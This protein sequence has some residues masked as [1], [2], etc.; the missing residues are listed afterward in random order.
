M[1]GNIQPRMVALLTSQ[2]DM[3]GFQ[4]SQSCKSQLEQMVFRG[5][6]RMKIG[7]AIDQPGRVLQAE[8]SL[9]DMVKYFSDYARD[10]GT[11]PTINESDFRAA[12]LASPPFWPYHS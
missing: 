7:G 11:Y 6:T 1:S 12:L 9:R 3:L 10:A 2:L 5:I 8:K 4:P